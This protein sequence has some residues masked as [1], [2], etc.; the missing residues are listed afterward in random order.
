M[1]RA[2]DILKDL[3][4]R[5]LVLP[6]NIGCGHVKNMMKTPDDYL[7][8]TS[9]MKYFLRAY[10]EYMWLEDAA[11][12]EADRKLLFVVLTGDHAESAI[13]SV[14]FSGCVNSLAPSIRSE[15]TESSY[16]IHHD[17]ASQT[18]RVNIAEFFVDTFPK[19]V[20][21][22]AR[23]VEVMNANY[24]VQLNQTLHR[25]AKGLPIYEIT[26][27]G[28]ELSL[29]QSVAGAFLVSLVAFVM[30][31][32]FAWLVLRPRAS[33]PDSIVALTDTVSVATTRIVDRW[34]KIMIPFFIVLS[35]AF[36]IFFDA[37]I[38]V[39]ISFS[40]FFPALAG[41]LVFRFTP[42]LKARICGATLTSMQDGAQ[43]AIQAGALI[44]LV[45]VAPIFLWLGIVCYLFFLEDRSVLTFGFGLTLVNLMVRV[46]GS[47]FSKAIQHADEENGKRVAAAAHVGGDESPL[48]SAADSAAASAMP[49]DGEKQSSELLKIIGR[50]IVDV[51]G[52]SVDLAD[53]LVSALISSLY[54]G[55]AIY[56][57]DGLALPLW[58]VSCGIFSGMVSLGV[59]SFFTRCCGRNSE[60]MQFTASRLGHDFSLGVIDQRKISRILRGGYYLTSAL[61]LCLSAV[62]V[63]VLNMD[64][65]MYYCILIGHLG[66]VLLSVASELATSKDDLGTIL[67]QFV[68]GQDDAA[69]AAAAAA[70]VAAAA[71]APE[72]SEHP[73]RGDE[74]ANIASPSDGGDDA[75]SSLSASASAGLV[76]FR[77][78]MRSM[79]DNPLARLLQPVTGGVLKA[80]TV[81][82]SSSMVPIVVIFS[83]LLSCG[84][85]GGTWGITLAGVSMMATSIVSVA[86]SALSPILSG[87]YHLFCISRH[88]EE[89][90]TEADALTWIGDSAANSVKG[91]TAGAASL[92]SFCLFFTFV[93]AAGVD[94]IDIM[95]DP[96]VLPGLMLGSTM[97]NVFAAMTLGTLSQVS[98]AMTHQPMVGAKSR[99]E[100]LA[101]LADS[102]LKLA[103][104]HLLVPAAFAIGL[105]EFVSYCFGIRV[106]AGFLAGTIVS[107][108]VMSTTLTTTGA[109]MDSSSSNSVLGA[110]LKDAGGPSI[111]VLTK[112]VCLVAI[113][114]TTKSW[115]LL[116]L[117]A[118]TA[119]ILLTVYLLNMRAGNKASMLDPTHAFAGLSDL[120]DAMHQ[121]T[122]S[123]I[124]RVYG[125]PEDGGVR[126]DDEA[127]PPRVGAD[128][129]SIPLT[130]RAGA[131]AREGGKFAASAEL[132]MK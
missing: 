59:V 34:L 52:S 46:G 127:P 45:S 109:S 17:G 48:P 4:L 125:Q 65:N 121:R 44:G 66:G 58:I 104:W 74:E 75:A 99:N 37:R 92:V 7:M 23:F 95:T 11:R 21:D 64:S 85:T 111:N 103:M 84:N 94:S 81:G 27:T 110:S 2:P 73:S 20:S 60:L 54:V 91:F 116:A 68:G 25:L 38:M 113:I 105:T 117:V 29:G 97:P 98:S 100:Y 35:V 39:T 50:C 88:A 55:V 30:A 69:V 106:L 9:V 61:Y 40:T 72:N 33:T 41:L 8:G 67:A 13:M 1:Y 70:A 131:G 53:S 112:L 62:T 22:A 96:Q 19:Y 76:K 130:P 14:K 107:G 49:T 87:A 124:G 6:A 108:L 79:V 123:V 128:D 16:F 24:A 126:G 129:E 132:D 63:R 78:A 5:E 118:A 114:N 83:I 71:A 101:R 93:Q 47:I 26:V 43:V 18:L 120:T 119:L 86:Y 80:L 51:M 28:W 15:T 57:D 102:G 82:M 32:A 31:F 56:G 36:W 10:F 89:L 12:T 90:L 42:I 115:V 122:V 3:L 77:Q